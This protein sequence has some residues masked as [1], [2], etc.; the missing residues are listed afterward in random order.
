MNRISDLI[1][2]SA[3]AYIFVKH[4]EEHLVNIGQRQKVM[5]KIC[6]KTI[7]QIWNEYNEDQK[8]RNQTV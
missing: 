1:L 8:L 3:K 2:E 6:G 5:C 4:I 7:N